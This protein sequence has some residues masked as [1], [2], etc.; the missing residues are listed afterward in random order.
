MASLNAV[1]CPHISFVPV[2]DENQLV[3]CQTSGGV[4]PADLFIEQDFALYDDFLKTA[5]FTKDKTLRFV[6]NS[7]TGVQCELGHYLEDAE[8][9]MECL[10]ACTL[11]PGTEL[12]AE[13]GTCT[14]C[15]ITG[16]ALDE[17][18]SP[19][20]C[21]EPNTKES[22]SSPHNGRKALFP[23]FVLMILMALYV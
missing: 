21:R 18:S 8:S 9:S 19:P 2:E 12:D 4:E 17:S 5:G 3:K 13:S 7:K 20:K 10:N 15:A 6:S 1:H 14:D 23:A 11:I 16:R 22:S